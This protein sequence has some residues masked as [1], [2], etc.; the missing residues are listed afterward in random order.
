VPSRDP[1]VLVTKSERRVIEEI[2]EKKE[3]GEK[4]TE[5][6]ARMVAYSPYGTAARRFFAPVAVRIDTKREE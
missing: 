6:E 4:L 3:R 1:E 2:L 5:R